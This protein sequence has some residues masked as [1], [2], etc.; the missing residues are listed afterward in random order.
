MRNRMYLQLFED[1]AGAGSAGGQGNNAG[2]GNGGQ[3]GNAGSASGAQGSGTYTYEQAEEIASA[4]ASK[5]ERT[6]LADFF[7]KQGMTEDEV[8]QAI[9]DFKTQKAARQPNIDDLQRELAEEKA[10]NSQYENE[11]ILSKK[12]VRSEDL[13]YVIFKAAQMVDDKI[14]FAKAADKFLK[15][16]PRF[17][18]GT[19]GIGGTYRVSTG[20]QSSGASGTDNP[21]DSINA[22]IRRAAGR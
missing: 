22:A 17:I 4:R 1:G 11:K 20:A 6:A 2:G 19:G 7:R 10:K 14:D 16:N 3:N 9:H 15:E 12:G 13:D 8:T 21:N 18:G 5:A